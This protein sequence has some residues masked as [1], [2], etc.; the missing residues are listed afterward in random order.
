MKCIDELTDADLKGKYV[1]VRAGLD[2]PLDDKGNVADVYR[3]K[4]SAETLILLRERGAR[5]IILS[6]IGRDPKET[7]EPVSRALRAHVQNVYFVPDLLGAAAQSARGAMQDGDILLLENLRRDPR[8]TKNDEGFAKELAAMGDIY[9]DDAFSN[10]HREHA[11]M[12]GIPKYL[13][14]YAGILM[15]DE[16]RELTAARS[17]EHPSFAILGGAKFETKEPLITALLS[18]YEQVFVTGA[19]SN[20]VFKAKGY[21]VGTSLISEQLPGENVLNDPHF[22]APIDVTVRRPDGQARTKKATEVAADEMIVDIGPD[23]VAAIAPS[24][25]AA[26][27]ILWNGPTGL[28]EDGFTAWTHAIAELIAGNEQAHKVIGGGDTVAA[29]MESGVAVDKL[30]FLSTGGGA[31]LDF[32]L[33]GTL[34]AIEALN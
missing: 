34:P 12:V 10:A 21:E 22:V 16:V 13:P 31:M 19:L 5:T 3:V 23:T 27:Y 24:I 9:V 6:H 8:E 32:L 30:G 20:D 25:M 2:V 15:R 18:S 29:I 1:L 7:N 4:R 26:K 28:Y 17:P 14:H 33:H 11:S